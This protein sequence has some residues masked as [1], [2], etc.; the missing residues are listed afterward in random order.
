MKVVQ[1]IKKLNNTE[2][3]KSGTHE[4][5]VQVP[6]DLIIE[7][8]LPQAEDVKSFIYKRTGKVYHIRF[9]IGR[10]KRIVG[11]GDFYRDND[12]CAG[13][14]VVLE[15]HL[16]EDGESTYY[17]DLNKRNDILM[18]QRCKRGFELLNEERKNLVSSDVQ[19]Y[20]SGEMKP[21][22]V[23]FIGPVKKREDS[24]NTTDIYDVKLDGT[25]I[26]SDYGGKEM[27]EIQVDHSANKAFVNRICAWKKYIFEME[28]QND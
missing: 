1:I 14:E 7:D 25:S 8:F 15:R 11:L 20:V 19:V 28:D 6:Q 13:D 24:P 5:Y 26:V 22:T 27:V 18:I 4:F 10:E 2:L 3:G 16:D 23:E 17:I 12:V 9:T 21:I